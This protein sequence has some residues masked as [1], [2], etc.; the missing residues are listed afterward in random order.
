MLCVK[1]IEVKFQLLDDIYKYTGQ[2]DIAHVTMNRR[3]NVLC[4]AQPSH[5]MV[6]QHLANAM[7]S[8][9]H[10]FHCLLMMCAGCR[11]RLSQCCCITVISSPFVCTFVPCLFIKFTIC[12]M[13]VCHLFIKEFTFVHIG[14]L[15]VV[16]VATM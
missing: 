7:L 1:F 11:C 9:V 4:D 8:C 3:R 16:F 12:C 6:V 2:S 5:N 14:L 13:C 10:H 15:S